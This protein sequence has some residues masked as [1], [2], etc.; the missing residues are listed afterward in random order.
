[1]GNPYVIFF[2]YFI[3]FCVSE[4]QAFQMSL[5][6]YLKSLCKFMFEFLTS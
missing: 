5:K 1:M 2:L 6:E 4:I 3:F